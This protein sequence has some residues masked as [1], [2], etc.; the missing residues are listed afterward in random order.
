M[1]KKEL[2]G[3]IKGLSVSKINVPLQ[4]RK[5]ID[6]IAPERRSWND[7]EPP[8]F[9]VQLSYGKNY[10]PWITTVRPIGDKQ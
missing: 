4:F 1:H 6:S 8:R 5:I 3:R 10:E 2:Y 7:G 9:E